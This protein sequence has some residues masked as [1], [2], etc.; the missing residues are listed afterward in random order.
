MT[1][2]GSDI[3]YNIDEQKKCKYIQLPVTILLSNFSKGVI[4]AIGGWPIS[5][6]DHVEE[7]FDLLGTTADWTK[8]K[9]CG[10]E[11]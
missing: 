1:G 5:D 10:C 7:N 2:G 3:D 9:V 4:S 11:R 6:E 8:K